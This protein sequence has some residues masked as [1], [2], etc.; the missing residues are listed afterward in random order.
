MSATETGLNLRRGVAATLSATL[1]RAIQLRLEVKTQRARPLGDVNSAMRDLDLSAEEVFALVDSGLLVAFDIAARE[2]ARPTGRRCLRILAR[3]VE[4]FRES[5]GRKRLDL[6]WPEI[7]KTIFG[8]AIT[9][10]AL[11]GLEVKRGLNC[12][13]QHV[14]ALSASGG[15][16]VINEAKPGRGNTP[17]FTTASVEGWLKSRLL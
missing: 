3:S 9:H 11:T 12:T 10:P 8:R 17:S 15:F 5:R 7:F 6:E 13:R 4:K 16:K 14:G 1:P 2:D